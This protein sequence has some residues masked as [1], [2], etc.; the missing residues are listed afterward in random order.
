MITFEFWRFE[1]AS[2]LPLAK[3]KINGVWERGL[4]TLDLEIQPDLVEFQIW[5]IEE[6]WNS[7]FRCGSVLISAAIQVDS[8]MKFEWNRALIYRGNG[9]VSVIQSVCME[10]D[11]HCMGLHDHTQGPKPKPNDIWTHTKVK[12]ACNLWGKGL[13][14]EFSHVMHNWT[15]N[16]SSSKL[17]LAKSKHDHV[18]N[19]WKGFDVRNNCYVGQKSIL[20]VEIGEI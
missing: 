20:S 6:N 10:L 16:F 14:N 4:G 9:K 3:Q 17:T 5:E 8:R 18:S 11:I 15:K 7:S 13:C 2:L 12:W 1:L 19:G